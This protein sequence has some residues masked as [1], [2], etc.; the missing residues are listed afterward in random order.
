MTEPVLAT[1]FGTEYLVAYI[2]MAAISIGAGLL[3]AR[4]SG[5]Q[6]MEQMTEQ[7]TNQTVR[8][9]YIP[10][11]MGRR[12][13]GS[14]FLY[15]GDRTETEEVT[16][17]IPGGKGGGGG[18]QTITQTVYNERG[19]IALCSNWCYAIWGI[20]KDGRLIDNSRFAEPFVASGSRID[21]GKDGSALIY[22]GR[23]HNIASEG[24]VAIN[25]LT[26]IS[27]KWNHICFL[28]WDRLRLGPVARW[29]NMEY[30]IETLAPQAIPGLTFTNSMSTVLSGDDRGW[31]PVL[32]IFLLLTEDH[33][34]GCAI[35]RCRIDFASFDTAGAAVHGE[36]LAANVLVQDG[37]TAE[38]VIGGILEDIGAALYEYNGLI[39]I[40]LIR[41]VATPL[42]ITDDDMQPPYEEV[43][44]YHR[45]AQI[46]Q[47]IFTFANRAREF[48]ADV[49]NIDDD[50]A[51]PSDMGTKRRQRKVAL[52]IATS[53]TVAWTIANRRIQEG[54]APLAV[55]NIKFLKDFKKLLVGEVLRH[56]SLGDLRLLEIKY[57]ATTPIT[58][59]QLI[60][61]VYGLTPSYVDPDGGGGGPG[62]SGLPRKDIFFMVVE[63]P[64]AALTK[65]EYTGTAPAFAVLRQRGSP[66]TSR[67]QWLRGTASANLTLVGTSTKR[68]FCAWLYGSAYDKAK[69]SPGLF[70]ESG[71]E[72][73]ILPPAT[74]NYSFV[75]EAERLLYCQD[76][77][78]YIPVTNPTEWLSGGIT[79][80]FGKGEAIEALYIREIIPSASET[81][82]GI[83]VNTR[84]F[85]KGVIR[86]RENTDQLTHPVNT[87][88]AIAGRNNTNQTPFVLSATVT[89]GTTLFN[90]SVA[91]NSSG[92]TENTLASAQSSLT[93][94]GL[95]YRPK[96]IVNIR[97]GEKIIATPMIYTGTTTN[98]WAG[99]TALFQAARSLDSYAVFYNDSWPFENRSSA[100]VVEWCPPSENI[101]DQIGA[102]K[103]ATSGSQGAKALD[104]SRLPRLSNDRY[105]LRFCINPFN[106]S[107]TAR[108]GRIV[109]G[110]FDI[111]VCD[112]EEVGASS[113]RTMGYM[114]AEISA[115][116]IAQ[117]RAHLQSAG[118]GAKNSST[119]KWRVTATQN[120]PEAGG[121]PWLNEVGT[122]G[123]TVFWAELVHTLIPASLPQGVTAISVSYRSDAAKRSESATAYPALFPD[124]TRKPV[125]WDA[126]EP[127]GGQLQGGGFY[128]TG[129]DGGE[130]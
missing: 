112:P 20:Y 69:G 38:N 28:W 71:F 44:R 41:T 8:G 73:S 43:E 126:N 32:C 94:S 120:D 11:V 35:P 22:W 31:N 25:E 89:V 40:R 119:G 83:T 115:N 58:E 67:S 84:Y 47:V 2:I 87:P 68:Q 59:M 10:L 33:P 4:R 27:S 62:T 106:D 63:V 111:V 96:K 113:S 114:A 55:Y 93:V 128:A 45:S 26:G 5:S 23:D 36:G 88:I 70:D 34:F 46:D 12:R 39:G 74:S 77:A 53:E 17:V 76:V 107:G 1:F 81:I 30:E 42:N 125:Q 57:D 104:S 21:M 64:R 86:K 72:I 48:A 19:W 110:Q 6:Q 24:I 29:G 105:V 122:D 97:W 15:T 16:G 79:A 117:I 56:P 90:R 3:M 91:M 37:Q 116:K 66:A 92:V 75:S 118:Y 123:Q 82:E 50:G 54:F 99:Q 121:Q 101:P 49:V 124:F 7:P 130:Y 9:G 98:N 85:V 60:Q 127:N 108:V 65:G 80:Y 129:L 14:V 100:I 109:L 51:S 95:Y 52:T 102:G 13:V 103:A 18:T 61:D 78:A